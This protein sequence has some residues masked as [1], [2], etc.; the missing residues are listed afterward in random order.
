[1]LHA[2]LLRAD[3]YEEVEADRS[4]I[5]RRSPSWCSRRVAT[6]IGALDNSGAAGR[7]LAHG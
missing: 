1:M 2:A 6:G 5:R 7:P 3:L 4:A